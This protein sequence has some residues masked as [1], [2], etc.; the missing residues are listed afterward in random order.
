MSD[1]QFSRPLITLFNKSRVKDPE[2]GDIQKIVCPCCQRDMNLEETTTFIKA[3]KQLETDKDIV[4]TDGQ[5]QEKYRSLKA[6]YQ[7]MRKALESGID[8]LRDSRRIT[9]ETKNLEKDVQRLQDE[10][11][12]IHSTFKEQTISRDELQKKVIDLRELVDT[13]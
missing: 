13:I 2:S 11:N 7:S 1:L 3:M 5:A 12:H 10:L 8:D 9:D 6:A 4:D